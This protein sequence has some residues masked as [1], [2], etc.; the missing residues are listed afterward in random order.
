MKQ[1]LLFATGI[2][3]LAMPGQAALLAHYKFDEASGATTAANSVAGG[4]TGAISAGVTT[5][6]AGINGS[7]AYSFNNTSGVVDAGPA[8]FLSSIT[9]AQKVTISAW[10]KTSDATGTRNV[11]VFAG[12]DLATG[13]Y[14][15][16]GYS[17][18]G[19]GAAVPANNLAAGKAYT[20]DRASGNG[21]NAYSNAAPTVNDGSWHQLVMTID[22]AAASNQLSLYVDGTLA[23]SQTLA[24][25]FLAFPTLNNFEI[26]RLGRSA[27]TDYFG[28]LID[29]VQVYDTALSAG[30]VSYLFNNPGVAVPEP[31]ALALAAFGLLSLARR[32]R[33]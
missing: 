24:G 12:N 21:V 29:D 18:P 32:R 3:C 30:E 20:R 25:A 7:N 23:N 8:S 14:M 9:T 16:L 22:L 19:D 11:A 13:N 4:A 26:G 10:V 31:R 15:D 28:G 2:C 17:G 27:P 6:Q 5:G 1:L 33:A